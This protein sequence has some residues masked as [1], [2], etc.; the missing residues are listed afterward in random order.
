MRNELNCRGRDNC[1]SHALDK[2]NK[3]VMVHMSQILCCHEAWI[4]DLCSIRCLLQTRP[5]QRV[6]WYFAIL[7]S[8]YTYESHG[9]LENCPWTPGWEKL[10]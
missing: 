1:N 5:P 8:S 6:V 4:L 10:D 2:V 9:P 3:H 7:L